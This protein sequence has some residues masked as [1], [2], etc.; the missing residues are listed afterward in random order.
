[1]AL[2][3]SSNSYSDSGSGV[4]F[5]ILKQQSF[6]DFYF[7]KITSGD[8]SV[9]FC[10]SSIAVFISIMSESDSEAYLSIESSQQQQQHQP[11]FSF[12]A[13]AGGFTFGFQMASPFCAENLRYTDDKK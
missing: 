11:S 6:T 12:S 7:S 5:L 2:D 10:L 8:E 9:L 3:F 4:R 13:T 1:M